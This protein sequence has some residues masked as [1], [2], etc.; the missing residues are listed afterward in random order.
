M[1]EHDCGAALC[2]LRQVQVNVAVTFCRDGP[3]GQHERV[4]VIR[5][6]HFPQPTQPAGNSAIHFRA[7]PRIRSCRNEV[8]CTTRAR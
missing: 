6:G 7:A 3:G 2:R 1:D 8:Q 4:Q 5:K